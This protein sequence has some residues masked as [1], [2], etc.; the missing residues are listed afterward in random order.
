MLITPVSESTLL[1]QQ[2]NAL[3]SN[4]SQLETEEATNQIYTAPDQA[5]STVVA[6]MNLSEGIAQAGWNQTNLTTANQVLQTTNQALQSMMDVFNQATALAV[7]AS[8][9]TQDIPGVISSETA[10]AQSLLDQFVSLLNTQ[11]QGVSV[12]AASDAFAPVATS[13]VV[14]NLPATGSTAWSWQIPIGNQTSVTVT[15]NG[16]EPGI[17]PT[18]TSIFQN[19]LSAL[20]LLVTAVQANRSTTAESGLASVA[21]QINTLEAYMGAQQQNVQAFATDNATQT[22]ALQTALATTDGPN[23]PSVLSQLTAESTSYQ[24]ALQ[25]TNALLKMNSLWNVM[26]F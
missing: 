18:S 14:T 17:V 8:S 2:T 6:S 9:Q 19:A 25:S 13:T 20:N 11:S 16:F 4:M 24:A 5:P 12:F 26:T 23:L 21:A 22:T 7:Q 15:A 3:Q 10:T 1:T